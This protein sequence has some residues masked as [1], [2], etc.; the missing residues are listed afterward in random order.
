MTKGGY[1]HNI[2]PLAGYIVAQIP[3]FRTRGN[4]VIQ[5][6]VI[7]SFLYFALVTHPATQT[8]DV[9]SVGMLDISNGYDVVIHRHSQCCELGSIGSRYHVNA[10]TLP[11]MDVSHM[12]VWILLG[13]LQD[14]V[15]LYEV[16]NQSDGRIEVA[17]LGCL[18]VWMLS[19]HMRTGVVHHSRKAATP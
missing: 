15:I 11:P 19:C 18:K 13:D 9:R 17:M 12:C 10:I 16:I 5:E 1:H 7:F 14:L 3:E 6:Y 8:R 2:A 4:E